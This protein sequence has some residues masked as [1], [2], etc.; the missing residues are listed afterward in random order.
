MTDSNELT[1][2]Q[3]SFES[4]VEQVANSVVVADANGVIQFV[5][6]RFC[7]LTG[8]SADE[9]IGRDFTFLQSGGSSQEIS[10]QIW[11]TVT[12]G[13]V[14]RGELYLRKKNGDLYR[15]LETISP[16]RNQDGQISCFVAVT[17]DVKDHKSDDGA[18]HLAYYD[19]LTNLPGRRL[20]RDRLEQGVIGT[21]RD[22]GLLV[23]LHLNL[24]RFKQVNDTLGHDA[25]DMMLVYIVERLGQVLRESDTLARLSGD[26]F[27]VV[28]PHLQYS[29]DAVRVAQRLLDVLQQPFQ[30]NGHE[31]YISASIGISVFPSDTDNSDTL[32][33]NADIALHQA[34][35][36][37]RNN[38]CFFS[39]EMNVANIQRM[40]MEA[41]LRHAL[42]R[43]EFVLHYQPKIDTEL[44]KIVGL[45]ALIRW[46]HPQRGLIPPASF[47]PLA[48]DIGLII[49][50]SEWVLK[51]A[52]NQ[53][54]I[55]QEAGL[56]SI[57]VAVNLSAPHFRQPDLVDTIKRI[58]LE[59]QLEPGFLEL[60]IT[61]SLLMQQT[62]DTI[63]TLKSLKKIGIQLSIDDFGTS[64][65]CLNYLKCLPVNTLK[66]DRSFVSDVTTNPEDAALAKAIIAMAHSLHLRVIAEGVETE[67]QLAFF[68]DQHC[69]EIQGFYFSRPLPAGQ[70][71]DYMQQSQLP[72]VLG[73]K[74]ELR[75]LLLVD[76]EIY[77]M[78][79]LKR[80]LRKDGY[81]IL[82]AENGKAALEI[83]ST[84]QVGVIISDQRM[85]EMTGVEFL[86]RVKELYP[87][88]IRIV[89]S[90]YADIKSITDAIN[91]GAIY[92][93]LSK[94][95]ED[96]QI[97]EQVREAFHNYELKQE[98]TRLK[99]ELERTNIELLDIN[100][101]LEKSVAEKNVDIRQ[102]LTVLQVSQ[103]ILEHL[104]IAVIGVDDDGL[105]VMTNRQAE[106]L[107]ANPSGGLLLGCYL[108]E[109]LPLDLLTGADDLEQKSQGILL[110]ADGRKWKTITCRLGETCKS[111]GNLVMMLPESFWE[112]D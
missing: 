94:P 81:Q 79:S 10:E 22:G 103:E 4:L 93:F 52:C 32:L 58:L 59:T 87:D 3:Q 80:L 104:P 66:I 90:G 36:A 95:W 39:A 92:K 74:A 62:E 40:E 89:L 14:W 67:G 84:N 34:K 97:R 68:V 13:Q 112:S 61:E 5:N 96:E 37:G 102:H 28:A 99:S 107:F 83:L 77:I 49:P 51:T 53:L 50:M 70:C 21:R 30:V 64:F 105:V 71:W 1:Y 110:A 60:E 101:K 42:D 76:D 56:T 100:S 35:D 25:G 8:Y 16:I 82:S 9:A 45:E 108:N 72:R 65:S 73:R 86:R 48:E 69:D 15:S 6:P 91:E 7:L 38:F 111:R 63:A 98:N 19:P 109:R 46:I 18:K 44:S 29:E 88:T 55:W 20:L 11:H 17:D 85:P 27:A 75:T 24:N 2:H 33:R 43:N 31:F 57:H 26:E 41:E 54:R 47:I 12:S 78:N 23:L 106:S